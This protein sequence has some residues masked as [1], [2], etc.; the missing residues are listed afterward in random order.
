MNITHEENQSGGRYIV[1]ID[2]HVAEMTYTRKSPDLISID[3]TG[4]PDALRGR[5]IAQALAEF[6][7]KEARNGGWKIIPR[8]S[9]FQRQVE[10]HPDWQDI[11]DK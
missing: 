7:V 6:A 8:C 2:G 10:R 4:V 1:N 9:F 5:G 3:H 11:V